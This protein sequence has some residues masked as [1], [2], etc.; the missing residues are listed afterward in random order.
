MIVNYFHNG[1]WLC[2]WKVKNETDPKIQEGL[3]LCQA[4]NSGKVTYAIE[5]DGTPR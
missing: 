1:N 5:N 2:S 4:M 3:K